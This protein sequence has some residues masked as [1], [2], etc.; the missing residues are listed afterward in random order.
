[1]NYQPN[2]EDSNLKG[3]ILVVDD[4]LVNLR[5]LSAILTEQGYK[6]RGARDGAMALMIVQGK[7]PDLILLDVR[8]PIM[9]G[10]QVC[11]QLK[12]QPQTRDIPVI[13]IS[14]L[15]QVMDKIRGFEVGGVDYITKPFQAEETLARVEAH[16][17]LR[18]LQEQLQAQN[19]QL[20]REVAERLRA[21]EELR[22]A[23]AELLRQERLSALGQLTATVAH[24]IRNPLGTVRTAIFSIGDAI[25]RQEMTRVQRATQLAERNIVRCDNIIRQLLDY[26]RE[27]ELQ[28]R[29][30]PIDPWLKTV[31]DEQIIPEG[32]V[33]ARDL[34]AGVQVAID[35]EHLRRAVINVVENAVQAMK[36]H[37]SPTHQ[38]T[39][40]T[41][42]V[43][44]E[45]GSRL[46]IQVHDTGPGIPDDVFP[47]LFEPL[48]STKSF[49]VG[50]GLP[51]V[52]NIMEQH[53]G[54]VE[55]HNRQAGPGTTVTLW[56]PISNDGGN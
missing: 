23:Q 13:F 7:L 26:T 56:L 4:S 10:Y 5:T 41:R 54:G 18:K 49:G 20:Q 40:H 38:L 31:L 48:F 15:D 17:A 37:A 21:E 29:L 19:E 39:I 3:D 42:V 47:M 22:Q 12:S 9:D 43:K 16:L 6:V 35:R 2:N 52:K 32:L 1:M 51:T 25:E 28:L 46:E 44:M 8:M 27:R 55:I 14:A 24:E 30:T 34:T 50:L 36:E 53:C 33:C 11:E 45:T